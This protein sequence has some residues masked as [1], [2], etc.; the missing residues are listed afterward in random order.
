MYLVGDLMALLCLDQ[1]ELLG[2]LETM[3]HVP[4]H[5]G[6]KDQVE[7][8]QVLPLEEEAELLDKAQGQGLHFVGVEAVARGWLLLDFLVAL[9][10]LALALSTTPFAVWLGRRWG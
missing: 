3:A 7:Q 5:E 8:H 6:E 10:S 9:P 2:A 4:D 1:V